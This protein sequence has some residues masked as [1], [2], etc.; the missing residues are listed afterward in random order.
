MSIRQAWLPAVAAISLI[1]GCDN[2]PVDRIPTTAPTAI[3]EPQDALKHLQYL[4][5]R[6]DLKHLAVVTPVEPSIVYG[7]AWWFNKHAGELGLSLTEKEIDELGITDL[8]SMG[9]IIPDVSAKELKEANEKF[10]L[11]QIPALPANLANLDPE[12]VDLLPN[13]KFPNGKPNPAGEAVKGKY[14]RAALGAGIYRLTK[15]VPADMW[16]DLSVM[17]IKKDPGNAKIQNVYIGYHGTTILN[18]ALYQNPDNTFGISYMQYKM[19]PKKIASL[20]QQQQ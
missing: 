13:D 15:A 2:K 20:A 16:A 1:V 14:A 8:R 6:K 19:F 18:V 11:K 12:S 7:S 5:V 17:E 9:Y 3:K 10:K 4:A